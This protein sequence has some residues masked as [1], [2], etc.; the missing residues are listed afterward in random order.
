MAETPRR[1]KREELTGLALADIIY[2]MIHAA[3]AVQRLL[4]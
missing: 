2:S 3:G 1:A 4:R